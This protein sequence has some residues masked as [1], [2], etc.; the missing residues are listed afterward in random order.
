MRLLVL[1]VTLVVNFASSVRAEIRTITATGEYRMGDN[2]TRTDAKRLALQDAK[3]LALERAGTYLE[4]IT[5]VKQFQLTRD[6]VRQYTAG[7]VQVIEQATRSLMQGETMV[8]RVDVTCRV[9]AADVRDQ[10]KQLRGNEMVKADLLR[11]QQESERLQQ[12][13]QELRQQ[14][15]SA[16]SKTEIEVLQQQRREVLTNLDITSQSAVNAVKDGLDAPPPY[17]YGFEHMPPDWWVDT[18]I[19]KEGRQLF[20]GSMNADINCARCHGNDGKPLQAGARDFRDPNRM[21]Y[22]S[23]SYLYWRVSEGI[24]NTKM[25]A[26]K[27]KLS[28]EDRWKLVAFLREFSLKGKKWD[29]I[30]EAW[31]PVEAV[32][33]KATMQKLHKDRGLVLQSNGDFEGA[34]TEFR[35]ALS[36]N[37]DDAEL[38]RNLGKA[39]QD[40]GDLDDAIVE[41]RMALSLNPNDAEVHS[42]LGKALQNK[43]SLEGAI[44]EFRTAL[45]LDPNDAKIHGNL[46][47]ALQDHGDLDGAI[48]AFRTSLEFGQDDVAIHNNLGLALQEKG[49]FGGAIAEFRRALQLNPTDEVIQK[50]LG[51]TLQ[52]RGDLI[53]AV[54]KPARREITGKDGAPMVL[55]PDGDFLYAHTKYRESVDA[56]YMDKYEVTTTRY[57]AFL[58][59]T[60]REKPK[61]W[62]DVNR[63]SD[64]ERPVIGVD[65]NDADAYCRYYGKRLP[66]EQEWEKAARGTDGREYPWGNEEPKRSLANYNWDGNRSWKG[67]LTLGS[68]ES[69][70]AGKSP[71]GLYNMAGNVAEWTSSDYDSSSSLKVLR[72]GSWHDRALNMRSS[73]RDWLTPSLRSN[74]VGFRCAQD[75][76]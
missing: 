32:W 47:S 41:Y 17:R 20:M 48:T 1:I 22:F 25:R 35:M 54:P 34:V 72:G 39:L 74:Y 61:S 45:R 44:E 65:W 12:E 66:T 36:L 26:Y 6:E 59:V 5:E 27:A 49:D 13:N 40:K 28:K 57:A 30:K 55:V 31:V 76:R 43:G 53:H 18:K 58:Q 75:A 14:L 46:G 38:H 62:N 10:I 69:Y 8:V 67:Y 24:S 3:R 73:D 70:E 51:A 23:D 7:M 4:S 68:V 63:V 16:K 11:A 33:S 64:R 37:P 60:S 71:Y 21:K 9:N 42:N 52:E 50:N 56:F 19:V 15:A 2:D 29:P